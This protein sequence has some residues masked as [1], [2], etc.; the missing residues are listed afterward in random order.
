MCRC[1]KCVGVGVPNVCVCVCVGVYLHII[2]YTYMYVSLPGHVKHYCQYSQ[3][4]LQRHL[5]LS[6]KLPMCLH[7]YVY[8]HRLGLGYLPS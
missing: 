2:M 1:A 7:L 5:M 6:L 3:Y 8:I 4:C